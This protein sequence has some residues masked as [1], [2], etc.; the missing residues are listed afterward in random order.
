MSELEYKP[1][2]NMI[3]V[4]DINDILQENKLLNIILN[5]L[6]LLKD[7]HTKSIKTILKNGEEIILYSPKYIEKLQKENK[8][9]KEDKKKAYKYIKEDIDYWQDAI[10][11]ELKTEDFIKMLSNYL[12]ILG[13]KENEK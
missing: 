3:N 12:E 1:V 2:P 6:E 4:D 8:Q 13:D 11:V 5:E 9:L 7:E 10:Y